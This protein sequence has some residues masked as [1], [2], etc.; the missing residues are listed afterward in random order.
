M[1]WRPP[2]RPTMRAAAFPS[3]RAGLT[4]GALGGTDSGRRRIVEADW[5]STVPVV[6]V[7][8]CVA[9]PGAYQRVVLRS[10]K[11]HGVARPHQHGDCEAWWPCSHVRRHSAEVSRSSLRST[12]TVFTVQQAVGCLCGFVFDI[13]TYVDMGLAT[14][15]PPRTRLRLRSPFRPACAP[16]AWSPRGR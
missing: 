14:G 8:V 11:D 12:Y 16:P 7:G 2:A 9:R 3:G 1:S 4:S 5:L 13:S 15:S 10:R 6:A